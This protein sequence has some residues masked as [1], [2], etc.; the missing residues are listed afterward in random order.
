[1]LYV[2]VCIHA[3][4]TITMQRKGNVYYVPGKVNGLSLEFIF[5]TGASNVCLSLTEAYFML[6]NGYLKESDLGDTS[7]SQI[8]NG[9]IVENMNV[10][11]KEIEIGGITLHN[12]S[13]VIVKNLDAPLL[14][15]QSAIQKLGPIQL[16]GNRLIIS[17]GKDIP[18]ESQAWELYQQ[19]YQQVEAQKYDEAISISEKALS[20]TTNNELR[21]VLYDNIGSAYYGKG[22]KQKAIESQS[23][24]LE[25]DYM[26]IQAQYN[27]GVY[28]FE[29]NQ[30]ENALRSFEQ[31]LNKTNDGKNA[32]VG[33]VETSEFIAYAL[34]YMGEIQTKLR[35]Y[36]DAESNLLKSI[37]LNP[38][39]S[40]Y[41]AIADLYV[42]IRDFEKAADNYEKGISYE[43]ERPSNIK[44][45]HQLG[46]CYVFS[47]NN[48]KAYDAFKKCINATMTNSQFFETAMNSEDEEIKKFS[49]M[50]FSFSV[51][52]E[53]WMA[54]TTADSYEKIRLYEER[55][56]PNQIFK[57]GILYEDY[58]NL[59][60]AYEQLGDT[61]KAK[62]ALELGLKAFPNNLE[63]LFS[64]S[65][66]FS[67]EDPQ[68]LVVL[69]QI[70]LDEY[71]YKPQY[72]DFGTV[73][74]NIAW[75]YCLNNHYSD[76]LPYALKAI[77]QNP[78][79]DYS[80]ET[81][82]ELYFNLARYQDCVD[83][84][85]KCIELNGD[86]KKAAYEFRAK[87][88]MKLGNKKSANKDYDAI[89]T[90]HK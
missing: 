56:L 38:T 45:F 19:A 35:C 71:S 53:L 89:K 46:M 17:Q 58:M 54:R 6:K 68:K 69:K 47:N 32:K 21:G 78:E 82:G 70:L 14:L 76:G 79:H 87:S 11:L 75:Y 50:C 40:A 77:K 30:L 29:D 4:I 16:S 88:Y 34:G 73:N 39:S 83:A 90:L 43:P 72:F 24:A 66:M 10:N 44:R 31:V 18:S 26:C 64:K 2:L 65:L 61:Q 27:L 23:K 74:N 81:L 86:S 59:S 13:A 51:D 20:F 84:M 67:E 8:A 3:Q 52:A 22:N 1:M 48:S 80:W 60:D 5:D 85:T 36:K 9:Q 15:G 25:E 49:A 12:I 41:I 55:I 33:S 37:S 7:Y 62:E 42:A 57:D 63:L 28:Y